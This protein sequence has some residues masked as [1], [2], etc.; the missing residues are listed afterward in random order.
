MYPFAHQ[1]KA[2]RQQAK[3]TN[4]ELARLARVPESLISGLQN[5]NRQLGEFQARKIGAA[6][7]LTDEDLEQFVYAAVDTCTEKMLN[8]SKPYPAQ[9]LNL[10]AIQLQR[11]GI[12]A[13]AILGLS[14]AG[15]ESARDVNLTLRNGR[16]VTLKTQVVCA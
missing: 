4:R 2:L 10:L 16:R 15:D 5:H 11:A 14:I 8:D 1:L 6:L 12:Q 7:R 3:L 9:L 13:E